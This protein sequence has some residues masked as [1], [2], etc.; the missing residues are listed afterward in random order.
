ML[1]RVDP[2]RCLEIVWIVVHFYLG[3]FA[4]RTC[5]LFWRKRKQTDKEQSL[6]IGES[7]CAI[8]SNVHETSGRTPSNRVLVTLVST[9]PFGLNT[10]EPHP[11][12]CRYLLDRLC[13]AHLYHVIQTSITLSSEIWRSC[14]Q[15]LSQLDIPRCDALVSIQSGDRA[16]QRLGLVRLQ[17][18]A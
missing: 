15:Q 16:R 17:R 3:P 10:L 2:V 6:G 9:A 5:L 13:R 11:D 8:W 18:L 12:R 1:T 4:S 14:S 7:L